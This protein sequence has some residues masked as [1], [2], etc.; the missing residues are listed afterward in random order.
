MRKVLSHYW[1]SVAHCF[2]SYVYRSTKSCFQSMTSPIVPSLQHWKGP[3]KCLTFTQKNLSRVVAWRPEIAM[4]TTP[5]TQ[6][7]SFLCP[8]TEMP[9]AQLTSS[10]PPGKAR[11][12][13]ALRLMT[14]MLGMTLPTLYGT[15]TTISVG[16]VTKGSDQRQGAWVCSRHCQQT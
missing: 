7:R 6:T 4:S 3:S 12:L 16:G 1:S 10:C 11:L 9:M 8:A 5:S 14:G 13:D 15:G 2:L